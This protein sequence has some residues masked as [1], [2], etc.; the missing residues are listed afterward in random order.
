ME[1]EH[2]DEIQLEN[3]QAS[4]K[5][6]TLLQVFSEKRVLISAPMQIHEPEPAFLGH[7][8]ALEDKNLIEAMREEMHALEKKW[9]IKK[10]PVVAQS[11]AEAEFRA[12]G[13]C[14]LLWLKII[15][16]DIRSK[17]DGPMKLYCDYK[18]AINL[19]H[20]LVQHDGTKHIEVDKHF[21]KEKLDSGLIST[22]YMPSSNQLA[23]VLTKGL[24]TSRF[25]ELTN[26]LG[27]ENIYSPEGGM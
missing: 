10:H 5:S 25:Q 3:Q 9:R 6:I 11:S 19:A 12:H 17:R 7:Y 4:V 15:P 27:M 21:I 22:P 8:K 24:P 23:D 1:P 20:N 18:S 14:E 13:V 2:I 16:D 26:K